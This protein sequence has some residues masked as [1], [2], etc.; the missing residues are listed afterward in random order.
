MKLCETSSDPLKH[1]LEFCTWFDQTFPHGR[2]RLYY[3]LLWKIVHK[4]AKSPEYLDDERMLR[5]WEKLADNSLDHGWEIYQHANTI[6]SLVRCAQL[7]VRWSE[8]LEMRGAIADARAVLRRARR[9]GAL[10]PEVIDDAEDQLEMREV[11][12]HLQNKESGDDS[13][14]ENALDE[15]GERVAFT[16][17]TVVGDSSEAPVVRLPCIVGEQGS[18]KLDRGQ[19]KQKPVNNGVPA[20]Q[21]FEED[22]GGPDNYLEEIFEMD[23]HIER[24]SLNDHDAE[25]WKA[26]KVPLKKLG[27][28]V[29]SFNVWVDDENKE[30]RDPENGGKPAK[31]PILKLHKF[32]VK[33]MSIEEHLASMYERNETKDDMKK[34]VRKIDFD[35][36]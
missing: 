1:C 6:G 9:N 4:Y 18:S 10:P 24:F 2:Q 7:Y 5:I 3:S 31:K 13:W 19:S 27:N 11:R 16:R 34:I 36:D 17:L 22:V 26:S 15:N 28:C 35:E 12:R 23:N 21:V 32:L 25:K 14:D 8:D 33:D 30:N 20:F 29:S